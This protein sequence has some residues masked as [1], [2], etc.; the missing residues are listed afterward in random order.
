MMKL[1]TMQ[2]VVATVNQQWESN[3]AD[4][5]VAHWEHD[6]GR[7]KYWRASANFVF[8]FKWLG[9]D[10]VLR[11]NHASE[12]TAE[13]IQTEL[14]YVNALAA[15][16]V[17]VAKPI[18]SSAG[19]YVG[20]IATMHGI[21]HT[22]VFEALPGKQIDL[23]ELTPDQFVRWG[24]ALGELHNAAA[25]YTKPGRPTW[26]DRLTF[27]AETLPAEETLM[28]QVLA[29]LTHELG[30]LPISDQNFGLIHYDFELDNLVWAGEQPGIIDFDDSAWYWFVADIS[31]ALSD[32]FGDSTSK[33]DF[34][35]E[36]YLRFIQGYRTVRQIEQAELDLI[37]LF[38]HVH[39]LFDFARLCRTLTPI[40]PSGELPWMAEL[41]NKLTAKME[42]YRAELSV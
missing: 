19:R 4:E 39:H 8:F 31:L 17:R 32:L 29:R 13:A 35:N 15:A 41:R 42:F 3:L 18:R 14:D 2:A 16:G 33:V 22:V 11:F 6:A 21:F 30:Q 38:L 9:Q 1:S 12:R 10:Y 27:I 25:H 23:E 34:Q 26:Q 5:L 40:N 36:A 28:R 24:Q 7:P 20:S 37:P